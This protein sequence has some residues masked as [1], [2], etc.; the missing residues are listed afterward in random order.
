MTDPAKPKP[1]ESVPQGMD[2]LEPSMRHYLDDR[3]MDDVAIERL[4]T[5]EP[6][7]LR[8]N[9][10]GYY[11]AFS[12]GKDSVVILDLAERAAVKFDAHY[13]LTTVDP[14]ELVRFIKTFPFV[15]VERPELTMWQLI[16]RERIMPMRQRRFCC[17][18]LKERGGAGRIVVT[19]VRWEESGQRSRRGMMESCYHDKTKRYLHPIIDWSREDV[20]EYIRE[21]GLRYC[22]LYDEG[23]DR[24]GCV[25]C[26]NET[27]PHKIGKHIARWPRIA[28]AYKRACY[29][30][31][32][33]TSNFKTPETQWQWW[34][35]RNAKA[36]KSDEEQAPLFF[37]REVDESAEQSQA[38]EPGDP[39]DG[40]DD[41]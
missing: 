39:F 41:D 24:I 35:D 26:P 29:A 34:L 16:R 25:L 30:I 8:M 19:G 13:N 18:V 1:G 21:R 17:R 6:D 7:A 20:W 28:A 37:E 22:S 32:N 40:G 31:W 3:S 38:V 15:T 14:P 10:S 11:L 27:N 23:W 9:P 4:R 5:F 12:G 2:E 33:P 36:V